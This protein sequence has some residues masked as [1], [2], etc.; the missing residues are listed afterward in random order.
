MGLETTSESVGNKEQGAWH[1]A[2]W[3]EGGGAQKEDGKA[4]ASEV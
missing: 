2:S 3:N 1:P 4:A